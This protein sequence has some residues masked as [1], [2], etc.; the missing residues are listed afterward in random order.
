MGGSRVRRVCYVS[1]SRADFGLISNTLIRARRSQRLDLSVC[2]TGMHLSPLFG[3]TVADIEASGLPISGRVTA[4]LDSSTGEAMAKAIG[5]EIIGITDVLQYTRPDVV[6]VLGDRGEMLAGALAA[7]HLNIP[8]VHVHGGERS[9][10]VDEPIRHAVSKLAHYHFVTTEGARQ[11]LIRMGERAEHVFVT[12]APGLDGLKELA[13]RSRT[14]MCHAA[15][16]DP[17]RPLGLMIFHAVLQEADAAGRHA[18]Q[19]LQGA[20]DNGLQVLCLM[21]NADAGGALVRAALQRYDG[22]A[23]V[24]L[25][26]HLSRVD[27]AS[28]MAVVD[29]M[30]G[31]SS[32]GIIEAATFNLP[33]VNVGERQRNRER[34]GNVTDVAPQRDAVERSVATVLT[35]PRGPWKNIYGDGGAGVRIVQLL[36]TLPLSA[37]LMLKSNVY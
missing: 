16:F 26:T 1:G 5:Q 29:I 36:E 4:A 22:H 34:S 10:T 11:R 31:N 21:P 14:E 13:R 25:V 6:M 9:G 20:L 24:R 7:V 18:D 37:S 2:V 23:D 19:V 30:L 3:N 12:G 32:S 35:A 28:W 27:F 33:V 17:A 8:V 15:G